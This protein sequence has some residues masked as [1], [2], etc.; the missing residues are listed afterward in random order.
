MTN[1]TDTFLH[2]R[3]GKT[4][5]Q[6]FLKNLDPENL[7]LNDLDVAD[8]LLF[9]FNF[10]KHVNY[11][12]KDNS[13]SSS[14]NWQDFFDYFQLKEIISDSIDDIDA[15]AVD[16]PRREQV[17]YEKLRK[18]IQDKL[19][20]F[21]KDGTLTPHLVLFISFL[22]ILEYSKKSFNNLT[23]RHLDFYYSEI[24][25]IEKREAIEDKAYVIFELAK[26][27]TQEIVAEGTLLD[28]KK[29]A[30][31]KKRA[32]KIADDIVVNQAKVEHIRSFLRDDE[33][34]QIK[35][36]PIANSK[37]G[38]GEKLDEDSQYWWPFGYFQNPD[39]EVAQL[40]YPELP[41]A[42]LGFAIASPILK[43]KGG[44]RTVEIR[45]S[46]KNLGALGTT[47]TNADGTQGF[48]AFELADF[49]KNIQV[50]CSGEE[51]WL[52]NE[53]AIKSVTN[54]TNSLV[55]KLEFPKEF[56]AIAPNSE[57]L[58]GGFTT[59]QPIIRFII[60]GEDNYAFYSKLA[61]KKILDMKIDVN[62]TEMTDFI[63]ENDSGLIDIKKPFYPFTSQPI[64]G[65]NFTLKSSEIFDK[66]WSNI[67]VKVNWKNTPDSFK[68]H[69]KAYISDKIN[70]LDRNY[71]ENPRPAEQNVT[72]VVNSDAY[73]KGE[74]LLKEKESWE[75]RKAGVS[76]F[77]LN[78]NDFTFS[79][80]PGLNRADA[81]RLVLSQ[82]MLQEIYPVLYTLTLTGGDPTHPIPS[83]AY[84]PLIE[85][86]EIN[87]EASEV[88]VTNDFNEETTLFLEDVYGYYKEDKLLN[89]VPQHNNSGELYI[90]LS[91]LEGQQIS[92]LVQNVEGSENPEAITFNEGEKIK[93]EVL[94]N[95]SW[96]D[97][98]D[99]ILLNE[100]NNFLQS[101]IVKFQLPST[102][103]LS[104]TR[105]SGDLVWVRASMNRAFDAVC[106][107]QGIFAQAAIARFENNGNNLSHLGEGL[108][109]NT[110]DRLQ[111]RVPKIK[112]VS[113]PYNSIEGLY[114]ETDLEYYRRISERLRHKNRAITQ[115]DYEYL[116]LQKFPDIFKV[117]CLNHTSNTS[118][119][120][121]G[122]VTIIVVP[123]TRN[124]NIFD[125]YQPRVSQNLL[126]E[127]RDFV[128]SLNTMQVNAIVMNP[129]YQEIGVEVSVKFNKG[130]DENFYS[131][132]LD[133]DIKSFISPWAFSAAEEISFGVAMNRFHMIDYLDQLPYVDYIDGLIIKKE[134]VDEETGKSKMVIDSNV[135][136]QAD[137]KSI[138]VSS[139]KHI[140]TIAKEVC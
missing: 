55:L 4:Q 103:N 39:T 138:F 21:E 10:A 135:E 129:N 33:N 1:N 9:A 26:K 34:Q 5:S 63:L 128:N 3:E 81:L 92:L 112:S 28:G 137:P 61:E 14:V 121:P 68:D 125:V 73:F 113:Q 19:Y 22:N 127:V 40:S 67:D 72:Y 23:K 140:V 17:A 31:G 44:N 106:K 71:F 96:I 90:G 108:P 41:D 84:I 100:T 64:K 86:I 24:L 101:G 62:V 46:Y 25:K 77:T 109:A 18:S 114:E 85:S 51:E 74:V 13:Q 59:N 30:D 95:N 130:Y 110:I 126:T 8:W 16:I 122:Y 94:S 43:L 139:K 52:L 97:L 76:L 136:I 38:L 6:R 111:T 89:I 66:K 15:N 60:K 134:V 123:N 104:N 11:F 87:Y 7:K 88:K 29:D 45:F 57:M 37:D 107:L 133:E 65:S 53:E 93:W 42:E 12:E 115:W 119:L 27:A 48:D 58:S 99:D 49:K 69:Y 102:L 50:L 132:K 79:I 120:A 54:T 35:M 56:P 118:Y 124:K 83:N 80:K 98:S 75:L 32:Y 91:A 2:Y 116:I 47:F 78:E 20:G 105:L 117:K 36:A 131:K 82:S 70:G